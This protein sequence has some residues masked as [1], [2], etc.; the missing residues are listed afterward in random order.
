MKNDTFGFIAISNRFEILKKQKSQKYGTVEDDFVEIS[1]KMID[2]SEIMG[3]IYGYQFASNPQFQNLAKLN[4]LDHNEMK[5]GTEELDLLRKSDYASIKS[6]VRRKVDA[7]SFILVKI[8]DGSIKVA[9]NQ[10]KI[11]DRFIADIQDNLGLYGLIASVVGV[12]LSIVFYI[13]S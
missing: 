11:L 8:E 6:S 3:E 12:V 4:K 9:K 2:I 5:P 13:Y 10:S 7:I 1:K